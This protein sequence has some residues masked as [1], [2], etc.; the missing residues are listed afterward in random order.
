MPEAKE[1]AAVIARDPDGPTI[2]YFLLAVY[3]DVEP[4]VIGNAPDYE[5]VLAKAQKYRRENDAELPEDGL[6]WIKVDWKNGKV[7]VDSFSG[8]ELD[9]EDSQ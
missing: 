5:G 9:G 1:N 6:Y 7:E 8:G 3:G 2:E 4:E